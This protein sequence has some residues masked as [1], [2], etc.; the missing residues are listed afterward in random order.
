MQKKVRLTAHPT[1][2]AHQ[3][4]DVGFCSA[5]SYDKRQALGIGSESL[6]IQYPRE[7]GFTCGVRF[8]CY[9]MSYVPTLNQSNTFF[10]LNKC[11]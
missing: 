6:L 5:E 1:C 8:S 4:L 10:M 3:N 2:S 7:C 9:A 11:A